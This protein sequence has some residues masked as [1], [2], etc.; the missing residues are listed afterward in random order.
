MASGLW[1]I[2]TILD[3]PISSAYDHRRVEKF[4]SNSIQSE[5]WKSMEQALNKHVTSRSHWA[6]RSSVHSTSVWRAHL[7]SSCVHFSWRVS[8]AE[9]ANER[10]QVTL[11]AEELTCSHT[12]LGVIQCA[13]DGYMSSPWALRELWRNLPS[14]ASMSLWLESLRVE[15]RDYLPMC[16][17]LC[18]TVRL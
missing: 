12:K 13:S 5:H 15:Q 17:P 18:V 11:L 9:K 16:R 6:S 10:L 8:L 14:V 4:T 7:T 2:S 3:T 1:L